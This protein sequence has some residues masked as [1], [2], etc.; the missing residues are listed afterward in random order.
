MKILD[1]AKHNWFLE[2]SE[3]C[4]DIVTE[5]IFTSTWSLVEGYWSLGKRVREQTNFKKEDIYGKKIL[6]GLSKSIGISLRS[7]Y[8]AIQIY[9]KYSKLDDIPE[10]K[11]IT[12][13]KLITKYLPKEKKKVECEHHPVTVC[14]FCRKVL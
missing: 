8:R 3:D 11:S 5:Y 4:K 10:G 7:V 14:K 13:N 6:S 1:V 12:L 9:D 2:L